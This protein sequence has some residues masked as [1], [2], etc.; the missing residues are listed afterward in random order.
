MK[1][2]SIISVIKISFETKKHYVKTLLQIPNDTLDLTSASSGT[3]GNAEG[4]VDRQHV[5]HSETSSCL[6]GASELSYQL[7]GAVTPLMK[8]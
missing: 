5:Y 4:S 1:K 7:C 8:M 6:L 3:M 2:L